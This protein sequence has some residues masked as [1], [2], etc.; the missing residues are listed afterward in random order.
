[1][2]GSQDPLPQE[3]MGIDHPLCPEQSLEVMP[4]RNR[5]NKQ[6]QQQRAF[7]GLFDHLSLE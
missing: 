7:V 1:M 4:H 6:Q 5:D 3:V 2:G